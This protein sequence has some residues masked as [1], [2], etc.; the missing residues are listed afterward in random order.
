[1]KSSTTTR[2]LQMGVNPQPATLYTM[3]THTHT[4]ITYTYKMITYAYT[5]I[6]YTYKMI[7]YTNELFY[8]YGRVSNGCQPVT[9]NSLYDDYIYI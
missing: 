9:R 6:T 7:T 3:I 2:E 5:M 4:M 1:M 8:Y